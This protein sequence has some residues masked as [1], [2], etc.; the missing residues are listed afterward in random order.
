M[1][2]KDKIVNLLAKGDMF[3]SEIKAALSITYRELWLSIGQL[4]AEGRIV[5]YFRNTPP[6][7]TLC[8]CLPANRKPTLPNIKGI[9]PWTP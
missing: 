1:N 6:S 4:K 7:A 5:Q 3:P 9:K 8:F 2:T